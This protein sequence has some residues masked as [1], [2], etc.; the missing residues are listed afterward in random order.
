MMIN[1][2]LYIAYQKYLF[3]ELVNDTILKV[4]YFSHKVFQ[5]LLNTSDTFGNP[6]TFQ[7][8]SIFVMIVLDVNDCFRI[9]NWDK[10][11]NFFLKLH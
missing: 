2:R 9:S 3:L 7:V 10:F 11:L 8:T 5:I 6:N 4:Q 1:S